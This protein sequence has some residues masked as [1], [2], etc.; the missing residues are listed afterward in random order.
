MKIQ[1]FYEKEAEQAKK[2][3]GTNE[4][5]ITKPLGPNIKAAVQKQ[6]QPTY[7]VKARK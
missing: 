7:S 2:S 6:D 5:D 1:E 4:I 3:S